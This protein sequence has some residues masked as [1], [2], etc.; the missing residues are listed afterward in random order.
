MESGGNKPKPNRWIRTK[1]VLAPFLD[2]LIKCVFVEVFCR[3]RVDCYCQIWG[4]TV[5]IF[6]KT[7]RCF[8]I[9]DKIFLGFFKFSFLRYFKSDNFV[10][11]CFNL[12]LKVIAYRRRSTKHLF[13][14]FN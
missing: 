10:Q 5:S 14:T 8:E 9:T 6:W 7:F 13:M 1:N 12:Y 2:Y 11:R 3:I 4:R